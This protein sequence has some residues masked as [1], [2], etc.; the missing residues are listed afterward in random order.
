M[1]WRD[2]NGRILPAR[3]AARELLGVLQPVVARSALVAVVAR[4][5]VRRPSWRREAA[6]GAHRAGPRQR[7]RAH[8]PGVHAPGPARSGSRTCR[9]CVTAAPAVPPDEP[10]DVVVALLA[11][12]CGVLA[13]G[14]WIEPPTPKRAAG[15]RLLRRALGPRATRHGPGSLARR[16]APRALTP[17]RCGAPPRRHPARS[18]S[19]HPAGGSHS[20][21]VTPWRSTPRGG[22]SPRRAAPSPGRPGSPCRRGGGR[23]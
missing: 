5:L 20:V 15:R 11:V 14:D 8:R 6:R 4:E 19:C 1:P 12:S 13:T 23:R 2:G 18:H 17:G 7:P 16:P 21:G 9:R 22:R 3:E 10:E